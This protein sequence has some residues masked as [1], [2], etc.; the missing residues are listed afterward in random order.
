MIIFSVF[1]VLTADAASVDRDEFES[2]YIIAKQKG[3]KTS[4]YSTLRTR[5]DEEVAKLITQ[6]EL[7]HAGPDSLAR[8]AELNFA[9][10]F[11]RVSASVERDTSDNLKSFSS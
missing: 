5:D 6:P 2:E 3:G 10:A 4:V 11:C 7:R 8:Q 1:S 9:R